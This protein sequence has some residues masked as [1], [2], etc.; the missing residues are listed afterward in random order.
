MSAR[1]PFLI[2]MWRRYEKNVSNDEQI[3]EC[4]TAYWQQ[5]KVM[6][7]QSEPQYIRDM[8]DTISDLICGYT[9]AGA[10]MF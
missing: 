9:L 5:K 7:P 1:R 2:V 4:M 3:G 6:A 8:I 10:G